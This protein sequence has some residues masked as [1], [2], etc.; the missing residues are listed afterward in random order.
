MH[1]T[2]APRLAAIHGNDRGGERAPGPVEKT[3]AAALVVERINHR[4]VPE[5]CALYRRVWESPPT[6][7][8]P[9]ELVKSWQPTPLEFTSWMEGVTYFA[10]RREGRLVGV[11]GCEVA[12]GNCRLVS[13]AVDPG[14]RRQGVGAALVNASIEWARHANATQVW[15]DGLARLT[16]FS[17]LLKHLGFTECGILHKHEWSEDVRLFER[18][19]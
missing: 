18:L 13:I 8:L 6:P 17:A 19:L 14:A 12:H 15:S 3:S 11:I 16:A 2:G 9:A 1:L 4:D 5:I 7:G 10:A